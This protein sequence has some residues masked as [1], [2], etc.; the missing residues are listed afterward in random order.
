MFH[1]CRT[2]AGPAP[3]PALLRGEGKAFFF[4]LLICL[5]A[6]RAGFAQTAAD[7]DRYAASEFD[8]ESPVKGT[9]FSKID[10]KLAIPACL[11]AVEKS[12]E[13]ARLNFELGRAY[14]ADKEF[15]KA[16]EFFLKAAQAGFA[17][18]EVNLGSLYFN[19]QGVAQDYAE[20]ARWDRRAA[21]Q[22]LA[23]AQANLAALYLKGQGVAQ[24][25]AEALRLL[26]L[27]AAQGFAPAQNTLGT[28]YASGKTAPPD[29]AA[30]LKFYRL[31][32]DQGYAP[33]QANLGAMYA[34]GRGVARSY[35]EAM[36]WNA[37]AAAQGYETTPVAP[38][39]EEENPPVR[40]VVRKSD[41]REGAPFSS[42]AIDVSPLAPGFAMSS[43]KVNRGQ[44]QA[45]FDDPASISAPGAPGSAPPSPAESK[46]DAETMQKALAKI[47][48]TPPP[49]DPPVLAPMGQFMTFY[50]NAAACDLRDVEVVVN[51]REWSWP[52]H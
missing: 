50:V 25:D 29:L 23:P 24:D 11:A 16:R 6:A 18:A 49:F 3:R 19:G 21:D 34:N 7:C 27:A 31:A 32:A 47:S 45:Y 30:A 20:A 22:G 13:S 39:P 36:K 17:L 26:L 10:P 51:G 48:I 43:F 46:A 37:L 44:C 14:D 8:R 1:K 52:P 9:P 12:P 38:P 15:S 42:T 41:A 5:S 4:A 40:I 2:G 33:A 35:S 28:I